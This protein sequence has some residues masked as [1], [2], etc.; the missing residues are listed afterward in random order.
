M[1]LPDRE[2]GQASP[3]V[4]GNPPGECR[5]PHRPA[6][7]KEATAPGGGP[8]P[9]TPAPSAGPSLGWV[10]WKERSDGGRPGPGFAGVT[11][12]RHA[13]YPLGAGGGAGVERR[14][15]EVS[16]GRINGGDPSGAETVYGHRRGPEGLMQAKGAVHWEE[17]R[18]GYQTMEDQVYMGHPRKDPRH[19]PVRRSPEACG[20]AGRAPATRGGDPG[21]GGRAL[22]VSTP[23]TACCLTRTQR[24]ALA[25]TPHSCDWRMW[26]GLILKQSI[27]DAR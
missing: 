8:P 6:I 25:S 7:K 4:P 14:T 27:A 18:A 17:Q 15:P 2:R 3:R 24:R 26:I 21:Q 20:P 19:P 12:P 1:H 23:R 9:G 13:G 22:G 5:R 11:P 10:G 16:R